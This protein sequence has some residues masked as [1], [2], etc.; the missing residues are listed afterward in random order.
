ML[1]KFL[2][3]P[4]AGA[5]R[6]L[7]KR[8]KAVALFPGMVKAG[9]VIGGKYG[10]GVI[11]KRNADGTWSPPAF[12]TIGGAT[13]GFQIGA[14]STDLFMVVMTEKGLN[15]ILKNQVKFG[16][17]ASATAGPW[18]RDAEAG[19]AGASL[20]AD[21]YSYSRSQGAFAGATL[22]G[23]GIEYEVDTNNIY[24]E[25]KVTVKKIFDDKVTPPTGAK[26]LM[27]TLGESGK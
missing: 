12:F 17:D 6:W 1:L 7:V 4:D 2:K 25:K 27:K 19:L 3:S 16:V 8:S 10:R 9:F 11:T 24:Y 21:V 22:S 15:A 18:G 5:P 23:A 20:K 26:K 13:V 14:Q